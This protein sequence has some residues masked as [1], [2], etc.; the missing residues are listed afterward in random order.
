MSLP[1]S[2]SLFF[3]ICVAKYILHYRCR[4]LL[5]FCFL[6]FFSFPFSLPERDH[7]KIAYFKVDFI[8]FSFGKPTKNKQTNINY[9]LTFFFVC[10]DMSTDNSIQNL[11]A[12]GQTLVTP[13]E[14]QALIQQL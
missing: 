11:D 10:L 6:F 12:N 14:R 3:F 13:A 4:H 7:L 9:S 8:P 5:S 1:P 2:L